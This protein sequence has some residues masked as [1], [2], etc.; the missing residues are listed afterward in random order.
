MR[1][2]CK[3]PVDPTRIRQMPRQ[4]GAID[5]QFI[6]GE[7]ISRLTPEETTLYALLICVSDPQGLSYYSD[8]RLC[9][10]LRLSNEA[11]LRARMGLIRNGLIVYERPM[12]QLLDL[13]ERP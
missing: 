4:F 7:H 5:R 3:H 9:E 11:V 6:F 1:G 12:Y 2:L 13:P 8:R 10:I